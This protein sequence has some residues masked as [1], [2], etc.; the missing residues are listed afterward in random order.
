MK[1]L[2]LLILCICIFLS[3]AG[4][5]LI[6]ENSSSDIGSMAKIADGIDF[7]ITDS[8]LKIWLDNSHIKGIYLSDGTK[9]KVL[10]FVTTED[11]KALLYNATSE[12]IGSQLWGFAD[13]NMIIS[14]T[15]FAPIE[16]GELTFNTS[17]IDH[18]Y[19]YN[20]LTKAKDKMKGVVPP[21]TLISEEEA[22][23]EVFKSAHTFEEKVTDVKIELK[24]DEKDFGWK[25][26]IDFNSN[27]KQ[28]TT[29]VNA[30]DGIV[31]VFDYK[32]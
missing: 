4:C 8:S 10:V 24:I 5:K 1:K 11:G 17:H 12:N 20:Y 15:I 32:G 30:H 6:I 26:F 27:G 23:S 28:F 13:K 14:G 25:Y 2:I 3:F 31:E 21:E 29:V 7:K 19:L 22:K 18:V 16:N 9:G